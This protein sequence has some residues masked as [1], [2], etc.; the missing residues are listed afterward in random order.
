MFLTMAQAGGGQLPPF[1]LCVFQGSTRVSGSSVVQQSN[2]GERFKA[3]RAFLASGL[4]GT[5]T[6]RRFG[7]LAG[8]PGG[9]AIPAHT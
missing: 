2:D 8:K 1:D 5:A 9:A 4:S 3:R 7:D 6:G